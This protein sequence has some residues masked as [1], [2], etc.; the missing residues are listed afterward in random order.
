MLGIFGEFYEFLQGDC[1]VDIWYVIL[2][3]LCMFTCT[4]YCIYGTLEL[5]CNCYNCLFFWDLDYSFFPNHCTFLLTCDSDQ[6][7]HTPSL[8]VTHLL[9]ILLDT[10]AFLFFLLL[11]AYCREHYHVIPWALSMD[12]YLSLTFFDLSW[13]HSL[14]LLLILSHPLNLCYSMYCLITVPSASLTFHQNTAL[15]SAQYLYLAL[16]SLTPFFLF[17]MFLLHT[18]KAST[19]HSHAPLYPVPLCNLSL[20]HQELIHL[21]TPLTLTHLIYLEVC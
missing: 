3:P 2:C 10:C 7:P 5:C 12:P 13:W 19:P 8:L 9:I 11:F 21:M 18:H 1:G 14:W 4:G 17:L 6:A 16:Y 20:S 15:I